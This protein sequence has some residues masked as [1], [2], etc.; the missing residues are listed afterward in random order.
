MKITLWGK[1]S[2]A[3]FMIVALVFSSL[4]LHPVSVSA[5][6]TKVVLVGDLQSKFIST[7][8]EN[9]GND[10]DEKSVVT[11]MTYSDNGLYTFAGTLPAG[12]YNY[13]VALN[14][15]WDENYGFAKYTNPQGKND[16]ENIHIKLEEE[17]TVTFYYNDITHKIA[18]STYYTPIAADK[19]PRLTGNLPA[20]A[21]STLTDSDFDGVYSTVV[22]VPQGDYTYKVS[23]PG[24]TEAEDMSYPESDLA[25]SLPLDLKV[26]FKYNTADHSVTAEYKIPTEPVEVTPVPAGHIRVHYKASDYTDKGLW[27]W[28]DVVN[29]SDGWAMGATPFPEGQ[30]DSYGAYVDVPIKD[31]A[32]KIS[33]IALKRAS[34]AKDGGDKNFSINTPQ[35]NE[36]W[37]TEGSDVVTPYEPVKLPANTVRIHYMRSDSNQSQYGLWLWDDVAVSLKDWPKD[38]IPFQADQVG[39]FG[40]YIDIPLKEA[41]KKIGFLVVNP[42]NGDN[43]DGGDKGFTLLDRYN[44]LWIKEGD[45]N[46]YVSPFGET[47]IGLV[48]AEV[49]STS[50]I[51]LGFTLTDGL[52]A[53]ALKNEITVKDKDGVAIPVSAV[54]ITSKTSI[55]VDTKAFDLDKVPLSVTYSGKTVSAASGWRMLDEMYN[56][57]GDDLGATYNADK[58]ATLKLWAPKASSVVVN[59][60]DKNDS[61]VFVG[62]VDLTSGE[63]GVWSVD[64]KP[65]DLTGTTTNDVRGFFYQYEV[66]ND[67]VTNKVLD[68]YA[69]SMAVFTVDTTG[70][71]GA[72]GDTVGKAAIVDLS[73]TNPDTFGY[74]DIKGYEKRED[75]IIYEVHVRDF[76]SDVS[77]QDSLSGERWGSYSA[78]EKKLDYIKS[79]GVTHIQLLPVMAWYY[80]DETKMDTRESD[81]SAKNNEY[82]WGYDPHSYFSPDGAYSQKPADPEERIKELKGL[83]DAVHEAGMG[84]ILDVV[85]THMAKKEFLNDIVPNYYAFQDANGNFIGGFG[86]NLATNHKMAEKLMVDSVK[87][88][89]EEYKIDGMRWDMMGDATAEAVQH[90]Y[91]AAAAINPKALFIGEGWRT[92]GG[93]AADPSLAGKGADQDWMDKTDSVGVFSDEF[94]N[95]LKSGYGSEGQPRFITGG[96]RPIATIFNN[97]KAEPSNTPADDPGDIVPYIEAHDNLTLHDVIAQTIKKDPK[98]AD[99]ELEIQKRIRLGNMLVLTSQGTA[100]IHAGQEYGRTKQWNS[101]TVP[102]DKYTEMFDS[103][104]KSFGYF[105]HDSYD[106]SDAVNMFDWTKATDESQF[107][108]QNTTR[109]YTS[110]L[111]ELRKSTDAFR[112]GDK[113]L[114]DSNVNLIPAPEMK[115]DDLVIGYSN[116]A[117][118]GTGIYYVFMNGDS[119]ARTLTL[120][121]DLTGGKVLVDNDEAGVTA[122]SADHK[123]GF[124]LTANSIT[125]D[126]LTAVI[127]QKDAVPVTLTSLE[128]DSASYTLAAGNT[129]QTAV[130]AKY[131]DNSRKNVTQLATY[132]SNKPE[133]ATVTNKGQVK[134]IGNGTAVITITYGG[135]STTVTVKVTDKRYVLFTYTRSDN[136]Y[137]DWN[138]WVWNTGVKNDQIDFTTFKDGKAS[139]LIE[140]AE[141]ATSVGFVLRKGTD[142]SIKDPY[143][144]D[145]IIPLTPGEL[146]TKVNVTS[147]VKEFDI[148]P[149]ISGPILKD[150]TLT[151]FYR[152][153][154]LFRS[155]NMDAITAAK[156][157]V[158]GK[159]YPMVYDAAKELFTYTLTDLVEGT[160]KYTFLITKNG[161]TTEFTDP[162]NTVNDESIVVYHIPD[163]TITTSVIPEAVTSNQNAIVTINA[164]SSE[165]VT[166][167]DGYM[168]LSNLGGSSK[169]KLD[170]NLMKQTVAVKD[171]VSAGIKNI[172][173]T[174]VDQYGNTHKENA[175]LEVKARTYT[176]DKLDFDWDEARIYFA[177]TD[178]FKDG[179]P[180]NNENVDKDQLE[181]YHGGDFRGMIDN[182]DYLQELGINTLWI[183]P[184]VDNI[185]FNKGDGFKQYGY[186]GYWA[187]DFTKLDEHL[188]DMETFKELIEK[189]HDKGIKI[190]VDVVLNHTGYGLKAED[191]EPTVT[192]EDKARFEGMLRTDGVSAD[193]DPIK[194][195]LAG[196]P[197]FKTEDPAVREKII[198]WQTGW[199]D[200]ARTE[201]GDTIDYFRVDTV[202]HVEDT[203][204]KA[205]K[206]AL[207]SI[208]P[209]FKMTGE[210]FGGTIDSN[211]GMLET[212][213]MDG[214]LDFG[215][216]DAAKDFTDGKVNS[217]DSYLQERELKIDNTKMMAQF[218]SS[219]DEDGFLSNYV[220]GDKGKLKIAAALQIT[221]KGQPVIYYGEEL[222]KS[223]KNAGDM[224]KGEFSE[225]RKDMPWDQLTA[226]KPLHDHYQKLLNIRAKYSKVYSKGTRTKLVGSDDLGYLAFNKSYDNENVVTVINT[227]TSEESATIPVPFAA[228]SSVK[229]EYSGK[230]YSVSE[231]QKVIIDLPGRDNG[232]TVI[233]VEASDVTP[234][235][236]PEVTPTPTASPEATPTPTVS[237]EATP[238]PTKTPEATPT[239]TKT[240]EATPT[241]TVTPEATPTVTPSPSPETTYGPIV[242]SPTTPSN[243]Q[244]VSED[245]L[246][247]VKEGKVEIVIAAGKSAVL[248]PLQAAKTLGSNDLVVKVGD[249]LVT[250]PNKLLSTIPSLAS[251]M[252]AEG[253]RILLDLSPLVESA[254]KALIDGLNKEVG[255][256][257]SLSDV[258]ELRLSILKKDGTRI[259]VKKF[260]EPITLSFK[261]KGQSNKDLVGI[262]YLGDNGELEYVGG[263]LNGDVISTQ[264]T[265]FSK[266]AVLEIVKSFKDVPTTYWAFHAI[267]SLAAK[268]IVSGVTT[269]EFNPKS[270]VSRAEFT[271]LLI[272]AL[273]LNADGQ[274][275][276]TDI[277]SDAWYS[278][279]VATASKL[280]IVSGRSKDT[281]APNASITRE[282][283]AIMVIRALEVKSGKKIEPA[284]GVTTFADAAS[285]SKWA[286]SYVKTAAGLGL[287]QGRENNQF[288]P[289]GWMTRAE[290]AQIIYTLMSK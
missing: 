192:A 188:G 116:K 56:Y 30:M 100:F 252:D 107:P 265:H 24:A 43:K 63:Q 53:V 114:V 283:M 221:A 112:L 11:Q 272:R 12:E 41:A 83:I 138:I 257:T 127:I 167:S 186:H 220:D 48:S 232:G 26:T 146:F 18:D 96:A 32:K 104:G 87:Y 206:N 25:L 28:G 171:T 259:V 274:I 71:A 207:T 49:L 211:G 139:V 130:F 277:K 72:G 162:K 287:L 4:G 154:A 176:G 225:N 36:V 285:I 51:L 213:Q 148:S 260:D 251:G 209:N 137:K 244:V 174:L 263:Q 172:P 253:S 243:A 45:N 17:T 177:L 21:L 161:I 155:G 264:V 50:K 31:G 194:G 236:T 121:E 29:P 132:N 129:H 123:T 242:V 247:N 224:S 164:S 85:Y 165:D 181:A 175:K 270:N 261:I 111:M 169:V 9:A 90:A 241:P 235:P 52:D 153:D 7:G 54:T 13:K 152:D 47:P 122:I 77:I 117:T 182:L 262:Y 218:L 10:W 185:D 99:N 65:T 199:L 74:A 37:I 168:D 198:A 40:A 289:K 35:T 195:E 230:T 284:V 82:N 280:G 101:T 203:T 133:V 187:K 134:A 179:D 15:S 124:S 217:V 204:W 156:V 67:G 19:F 215:F 93:A 57:T 55:E 126:P 180:T 184:I 84:V 196:L 223:G 159:A 233:L 70:A 254:T 108:V 103:E 98:N 222:G 248:L 150:G 140:V 231:D 23:V 94:R 143:G 106:S 110:G 163:V 210:Y 142:W 190:M 73:Q 158:N 118:D 208:D 273:G 39:R 202:K 2:F 170:T 141:N 113:D 271:A 33:F 34:G 88:W 6:T 245:S 193:T 173:I 234:T 79:L 278:S 216:N 3:I 239:P 282:E 20:E 14:D 105:I 276:F 60:Y 200:N 62:S 68:P 119:T 201:R 125:I 61:N 95:E 8:A 228:N 44:Q 131:D 269:T 212:G 89:F 197:D 266:Y 246:K 46:V 102:Q 149:S 157:K 229:D 256:V 255:S 227:K 135:I 144:D 147:G 183:T 86:N 42:L 97:I 38:A 59:V 191:N 136:D 275:K 237:P 226:E 219:H 16:G 66:T 205:F 64:L 214:L 151:F 92:F 267:Q 189:A 27:L 268:Q 80:G 240:P 69:K 250:I 166:Y 81:Y 76:T 258:F 279:Y 290:S 75:A 91:D 286:D 5:E 128:T 58:T 115:T 1:R 22:T 78:F 288:A 109:K 120:S 160:Y 238:T 178:R 281:F 249:L 145:R